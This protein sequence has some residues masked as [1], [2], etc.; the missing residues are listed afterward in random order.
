[1][2]SLPRLRARRIGQPQ[3][4]VDVARPQLAELRSD[5]L[6]WIHLE[7]PTFDEA[8][9]LAERFGWH[10]LD[11][12]DIMSR[13]E[14][15]KVDV[16]SEEEAT[17]YLFAVLHFP[18]YNA[19]V[20]R[21][22]AG[23]LDVFVGPDYLVTLPSVDLKPVRRLF[24][25]CEENEQLRHNLFSRGSGRLLYEVLD[26]LYDYCFPILDKIGT[27]LRQIDEEI[28]DVEPRAKERVRD[29]HKVKQEIISYR[30]IVRPQRPTLRQLE[31]Q[32]ERFLP[33]ELELYFDDIVDASERIWDNLDNYKEV[34]EALEDT[35]ES[36]IS[37][38]QNDILYVLTIFSVVM[39]PLTFLTGVFGMNVHF[40]YFDT[41]AG[42]FVSLGLFV[43]TIV[44]MVSFF[45]YKR[46]L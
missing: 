8:Q 24:Q 6:T 26:D 33:Q 17:G 31:R 2:P 10:P 39:L 32:I 25:R 37:H 15:P 3:H 34:V 40:P 16:Y 11:V 12:E 28:D 35:N 19:N 45:R 46:W 30:K 18:V 36:L 38:Q 14:R 22:D 43:A 42:F 1:M 5:G 20:G 9:Q 13:R 7:R 4:A 23:E 21:L 27:K 44:G 29:I 41:H